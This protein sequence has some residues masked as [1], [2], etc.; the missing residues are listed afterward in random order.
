[1]TKRE[2]DEFILWLAGLRQRL[3]L[4]Q[5]RWYRKDQ[6]MPQWLRLKLSIYWQAKEAL[7]NRSKYP[8]Q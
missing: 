8:F 3:P 4:K 6:P 5:P 1:M 7:T 2:T